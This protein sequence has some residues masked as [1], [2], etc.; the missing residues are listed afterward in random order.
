MI[1]ADLQVKS[2]GI[3]YKVKLDCVSTRRLTS[4]EWLL[5]DCVKH[6]Q[7]T[8]SIRDKFVKNTYDEI[9]QIQN[10]ELLM[11]PCITSLQKLNVLKIYDEITSYDNLKFNHIEFTALGKEM[12]KNGLIPREKVEKGLD[13]FFNPMTESI[14]HFENE[15]KN[16]TLI[17]I[18]NEDQGDIIFPVDI[19]KKSIEKG[20]TIS[21]FASSK[22]KILDIDKVGSD[23]WDKCYTRFILSLNENEI[24]TKPEIKNAGYKK[25][26]KNFFIDTRLSSNIKSNIK[27]INKN[28]VSRII[29][30]GSLTHKEVMNMS[31]RGKVCLI[32]YAIFEDL[33][34]RLGLLKE[35]I[36]I[37][38]GSKKFEIKNIS[39][40]ICVYITNEIT[41][42]E[43][44]IVND[45][46][47]NV[48]IANANLKYGDDKLNV[49]LI[50]ADNRIDNISFMDDWIVDIVAQNFKKNIKYY[51][52]VCLNR[53][54]KLQKVEQLSLFQYFNAMSIEKIMTKLEEL[55]GSLQNLKEYQINT[56][57]I[58][59]LFVSKLP[60]LDINRQLSF[61]GRFASLN[62]IHGKQTEIENIFQ[63]TLKTFKPLNNADLSIILQIFNLQDEAIMQ[64]FNEHSEEIYNKDVLRSFLKTVITK[65]YVKREELFDYDIF[66]NDY[67][68]CID[69]IEFLIAVTDI[70]KTFD[71]NKIQE[72]IKNCPNI[73]ALK[74]C[75]ER[76]I[77]NN[78]KL[79][80]EKI[81]AYAEF[82]EE[83]NTRTKTFYENLR[84]VKEVV[85][86]VITGELVEKHYVSSQENEKID[87]KIYVMDTSAL[88]NEP[89]IFKYFY[90]DEYI[91]IPVRVIDELGKIKDYH[92]GYNSKKTKDGQYLSM[93]ARHVCKD[94]Y[95]KYLDELNR[96]DSIRF[97]LEPAED[98][99]SIPASLDVT[100][101]DNWI[102]ANVLYYKNWDVTLISDDT[103]FRLLNDSYGMKSISSKGFI[104]SH[105]GKRQSKPLVKKVKQ[106]VDMK[107][108]KEMDISTLASYN[109]MIDDKFISFVKEHGI[110]TINDLI[111]LDQ[112]KVNSMHF[113]KS[114]E[115]QKRKLL[116]ILKDKNKITNILTNK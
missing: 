104:D 78:E 21:N 86:K 96:E 27:H 61:I 41:I 54:S 34:E 87:K 63:Y 66:F 28:V 115:S 23:V 93:T 15:S 32:N 24:T 14:N 45:L 2:F 60:T 69:K 39:S 50:Y 84:F 56:E 72:S 19:I 88:L 64:C 40:N 62:M 49:P 101:P 42:E 48:C 5:L 11:E 83:D 13:V 26:I 90:E 9:F 91:R 100:V 35:K 59:K 76:V 58:T 85:D 106:N 4:L 98:I 77:S 16:T 17:H 107:L 46:L 70:F 111:L 37:I 103:Q 110:K 109:N 47:D 38:F 33:K 68:E 65:T 71:L 25:Y 74:S 53:F 18:E 7:N 8:P 82:F 57:D 97:V 79:A 94:I 55:D 1:I 31:R 95:N 89:Y 52:L 116:L 114:D 36:F 30:L 43:C 51:L 92:S 81:N 105:T 75:V 99:K 108:D 22:Y 112:F 10:S 20:K 67:V 44:L 3:K 12:L 113:T 80:D 73:G 29:G 102:L 6:A